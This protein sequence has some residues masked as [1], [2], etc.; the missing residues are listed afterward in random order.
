MK[1]PRNIIIIYLNTYNKCLKT[2]KV[3]KKKKK[4][5]RVYKQII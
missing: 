5:C 3:D 4:K 2:T 1:H